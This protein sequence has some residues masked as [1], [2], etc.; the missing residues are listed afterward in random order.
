LPD[1]LLNFAAK[2]PGGDRQ[3][4]H[5]V[6]P[7]IRAQIGDRSLRTGQHDRDVDALEQEAESGRRVRHCVGAVEHHHSGMTGRMGHDR[8]GDVEP[9]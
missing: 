6:L 2:V 5:Q 1:V 9:V 4:G 7:A 3:R 8:V